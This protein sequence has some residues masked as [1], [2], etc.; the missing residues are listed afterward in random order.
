MFRHQPRTLFGQPYETVMQAHRA[1]VAELAR[2]RGDRPALLTERP[3]AWSF[4]EWGD[5]VDDIADEL[6]CLR[7]GDDDS[8]NS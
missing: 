2:L 4:N 5:Y 1:N 7:D 6:R 3:E 8:M